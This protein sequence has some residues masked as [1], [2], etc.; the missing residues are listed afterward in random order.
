MPNKN[1][2]LSIVDK[3]CCHTNLTD[4]AFECLSVS[5]QPKSAYTLFNNDQVNEPIRLQGETGSH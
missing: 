5:K 2:P 4:L 1:L 3:I